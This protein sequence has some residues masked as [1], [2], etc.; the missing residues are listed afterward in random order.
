MASNLPGNCCAKGFKHHGTPKG[1]L[2]DIDGVITYITGDE[3]LAGS[4]LHL[5]MTDVLG[6]KFNNAQ[7]IA[8]QYADTGYFV[9]VPD[10]YFEDPVKLNPPESF[11]L[12][13]D[14]L[15]HHGPDVTQPIV[16][17]VYA[18][19][20]K[21]YN[22]KYIVSTGYCYGAKFSLGLLDKGLIQ[23][24]AVFHPSAITIDEVK[25]IK[26]PL[27]IGACEIDPIFPPEL[28]HQTEDALKEIGAKY[29]FSLN[30]GVSHGF[31]VRG[32][33]SDPWAA[34]A[35]ER[36]FGDAVDWFRISKQIEYSK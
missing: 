2:I 14:W 17:K 26:G 29:R 27:Y 33:G 30:H 5:M 23:T 9:V 35:K 24:A 12:F 6:N 34:Y 18:Y 10:L 22:P 32:D 11:D 31:A 36:V 19:I 21:K 4:Q 13:R 7:L 16:D 1:K 15:P 25:A 20:K 8:D 28:R 3:S